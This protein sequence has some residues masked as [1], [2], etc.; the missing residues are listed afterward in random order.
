MNLPDLVRRV[1]AGREEKPRV[2]LMG[3]RRAGTTLHVR[4]E[5][6]RV[7]ERMRVHVQ[8]DGT[9]YTP[10]TY[11]QRVDVSAHETRVQNLELTVTEGTGF[12]LWAIPLVRDGTGNWVE[13]AEG[14]AYWAAGVAWGDVVGVP[15]L[16]EE[17]DPRLSDARTPT[18]HALDSVQHTGRLNAS[19]LPLAGSFDSLEVSGGMMVNSTVTAYEIQVS[20]DPL[21][22]APPV[23]NFNGGLAAIDFSDG[24]GGGSDLRVGRTG[25]GVF[26]ASIGAINA[27]T[28]AGQTSAD[29]LDRA[30][31]TGTQ[32][33]S[34][35][36]DLAAVATSGSAED[37]EVGTLPSGRLAG[38][39]TGVSQI[40]ATVGIGTSASSAAALWVR[41]SLSTAATTQWGLLF[42][43]E[44]STSATTAAYGVQ[45]RVRL[46]AGLTSAE[47]AGLVAGNVTLGAG[48][49]ATRQIGLLVQ[50]Q[51]SGATN[52]AVETRGTAR[53][54]FGGS[55]YTGG[56]LSVGSLS[57]SLGGGVKVVYLAHATTAPTS[58]PTGGFLIYST[59]TA[60]Y[61]RGPAGTVTPLAAP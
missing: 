57:P 30:H 25:A 15:P 4:I 49:A 39:Y 31:H 18:A 60:L 52:V 24:L 59:P 61:A 58:N 51:T 42:E 46:A 23:I 21:F 32:P 7:I 17:G 35:V 16:I 36:S 34:S 50:A 28:L 44:A 20:P 2:N 37:L 43:P 6:S 27:N 11:V 1:L 29:L 14:A 5:P 56:D 12:A 48:S 40:G 41:S 33:A 3:V 13:R 19:Q 26:G 55:V 47:V 22:A 38:A 9:E 53:S 45:G 8:A 54:E 10:E